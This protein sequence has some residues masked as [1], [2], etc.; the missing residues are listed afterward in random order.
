MANSPGTRASSTTAT[1]L[2]RSGTQKVFP[3]AATITAAAGRPNANRRVV[4]STGRQIGGDHSSEDRAARPQHCGSQ[5]QEHDP[6]PGDRDV[7]RIG[8]REQPDPQSR[9]YCEVGKSAAD[10]LTQ[11]QHSAG[12]GEQRLQVLHDDRC[13]VVAALAGDLERDGE[14]RGGQ[15]G[16]AG[17]DRNDRDLAAGGQFG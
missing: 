6:D 1:L 10:L 11:D 14:Q 2:R 12:D 8:K 17:T 4:N 9:R 13:H 16:C 15:R 7:Q 5:G 3:V